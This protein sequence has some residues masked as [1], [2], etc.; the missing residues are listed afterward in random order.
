M[1]S[2]IYISGSAIT[3]PFTSL[4]PRKG[5]VYVVL[6]CNIVLSVH[7]MRMGH[8]HHHFLLDCVIVIGGVRVVWY[9]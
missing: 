8:S 3:G 2:K 5:L 6:D 4:N 1:G 9:T 7:S